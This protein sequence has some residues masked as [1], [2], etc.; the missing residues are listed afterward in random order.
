MEITSYIILGLLIVVSPGADFVL[1]VKN[2]LSSG[3]K[4]GLLTGLGIG[5]GVCVHISYSILGISH[6]LS[7][8]IIVFSMIKYAGSAYLIYLGITGIF[9]SK[10]TLN[11]NAISA[12]QATHKARKY[13]TQGFFCNMLNPK[14]MLF[15]LSVFSQ[16]ISPDTDNNTSFALIYG[17]YISALHILWFCLVAYLMTSK[18]ILSVFQSVGHRVN[19]VCG[20]GLVAFGATLSLSQ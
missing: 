15:F 5:I 11:R 20:V 17:L 18:K 13:F 4:A 2:S 1:V 8:N 7:Q 19:Q 16:L 3:R 10:L 14:T 6:L 12:P 9:C